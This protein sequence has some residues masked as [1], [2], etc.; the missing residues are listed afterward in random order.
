VSKLRAVTRWPSRRVIYIAGL[1]RA[2]GASMTSVLVGLYLS[3]LGYGT[4]AIG[5]VISCSLAGGALVTFL[6]SLFGDWFGRK[7]SLVAM[8]LLVG[9]GGTVVALWPKPGVVVIAAL[10]GAVAT[11]PRGLASFDTLEQAML[12]QAAP[13]WERTR[14]FAYWNF[15]QTMG[16]ALG[17]LAAGIPNLLQRGSGAS[18]LAGY[19]LA[20]FL[21]GALGL[22]L[23][24][25]YSLLGSAIEASGEGTRHQL[26][27]PLSSKRVIYGLSGL[28]AVDAFAGAMAVQ[29]FLSYWF[30]LRYGFGAARLGV[31][32]FAANLLSSLSFLL[33]AR[34][35][36]RFGLIN[37][38]VFTHLPSSFLFMAM[39]LAPT[40]G[41][42][43][44]FFL[45]RQLLSQMDV[46]TRQSYLMAVVKPE[47]RT[48]AAG[49]TM[50]SRTIAN[51]PGPWVGA[52]LVQALGLASPIMLC[53]WLK[54][55]YDLAL[56]FAF[57]R[58]RP[59]EER[60]RKHVAKELAQGSGPK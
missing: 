11:S 50:L 49:F 1:T 53:G 47:E 12:A 54:V 60:R 19:R 45:A 18:L 43:M 40:G 42:A 58:T 21:Y 31:I 7:R 34:L 55:A 3:A 22:S 24:G 10:A 28:F 41:W 36:R 44:G 14:H 23:A 20:F 59:P 35:A 9:L 52:Y 26:F 17:A 38:M 37:T 32:F 25:I 39:A 15:L 33:A 5:L 46:P 6:T 48:A 4:L 13:D 57:R 2:F 30:S 27:P 29:S 56:Y 8:A 51:V 16:A